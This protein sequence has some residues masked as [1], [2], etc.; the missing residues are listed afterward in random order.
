MLTYEIFREVARKIQD[1]EVTVSQAFDWT[2]ANYAAAQTSRLKG[3]IDD[4][5]E[6]G[7]RVAFYRTIFRF[8]FKDE[9][10][11][12]EYLK[13]IAEPGK[14]DG[15]LVVT[16]SSDFIDQ[17]HY[18]RALELLSARLEELDQRWLKSALFQIVRIGAY[19]AE[20]ENQC[21]EPAIRLRN[22]CEAE[23]DANI[24]QDRISKYSL[25]NLFITRAYIKKMGPK[26]NSELIKAVTKSIEADIDRILAIGE[27]WEAC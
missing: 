20:L 16:L 6:I 23:F 24:Y 19:C 5:G 21:I 9:E 18:E 10:V 3:I 14:L 11:R 13:L 1:K 12:N 27:N 4:D 26:S 17:G 15:R 25:C 7:A 22:L 2:M 8:Y